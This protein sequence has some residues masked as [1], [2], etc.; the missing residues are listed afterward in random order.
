M[1]IPFFFFIIFS[2]NDINPAVLQAFIIL[3]KRKPPIIIRW[4]K[5]VKLL[6]AH[7]LQLNIVFKYLVKLA[8][9]MGH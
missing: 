9:A 2:L 3:Q 5:I 6:I 8:E 1:P 4:F 7:G